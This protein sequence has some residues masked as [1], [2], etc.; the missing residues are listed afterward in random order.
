[1]KIHKMFRLFIM[2]IS[3][4]KAA[5]ELGVTKETLSGVESAQDALRL[6]ELLKD[7]GDMT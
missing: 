1:M 4:G 2:K 6:S 7:I 5:E 3:I